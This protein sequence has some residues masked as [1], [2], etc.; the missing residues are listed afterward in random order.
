MEKQRMNRITE[1]EWQLMEYIWEKEGGI[2]Q[3]E[4]MEQTGDRWNKNTVHTFLKRLSDKGYIEIVKTVS[5]HRY[6]A[7]VKRAECVREEQN[8]FLERLYG[9]SISRM[10]TSFVADGG[11]SPK[12]A[13]ELRKLL[14][15]LDEQGNT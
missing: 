10:V 8:S 1:S 9:G 4:I 11:L 13:D 12:E 14:D 5:P 3:P 2:T 6:L 7:L 15:S